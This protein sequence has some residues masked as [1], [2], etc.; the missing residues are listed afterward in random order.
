MTSNDPPSGSESCPDQGKTILVV[1]DNPQ[2]AKLLSL[3]LSQAGYRVTVAGSGAEGLASAARCRPTAITL[4]LL[5]P[6]MDGWD[7]LAQLK[8]SPRTRDIPVV[9]VSVLDRQSLGFEL[10]ASDYLVKPVG[11]GE[12]LQALKRCM[13]RDE[14]V[15]RKVMVVHT[16]LDKL[17]LLA[18]VVAQESYEVILALGA[19]KA[20]WLAKRVHP[21]LVVT[22]LLAGGVDCYALLEEL[23]AEPETAH[24][25]VLA[26]TTGL[27]HPEAGIE[28]GGIE[29]VLVRDNDP[30]EE[31]L[32]AAITRLFKRDKPVAG[33]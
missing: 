1:E 17:N 32:L 7:V 23:R 29:F 3:Y 2:A 4:D 8:A 26:L 13:P 28:G 31:R 5:L 27:S 14:G 19:D 6:D 16:D 9:I 12:L 33:G 30:I 10:G 15:C 22:D 24:V 25:P 18:M 21:D 11:R 20:A